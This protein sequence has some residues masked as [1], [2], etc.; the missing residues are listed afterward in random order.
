MQ[1]TGMNRYSYG[2][3]YSDTVSKNDLITGFSN[4]LA[5]V[6]DAVQEGDIF[7]ETEADVAP[8]SEIEKN[9]E[10]KVGINDSGVPKIEWYNTGNGTLPRRRKRMYSS[11]NDDVFPQVESELPQLYH[12]DMLGVKIGEGHG[13]NRIILNKSVAYIGDGNDNYTNADFA[14]L[15]FYSVFLNTSVNFLAT[16]TAL[17]EN[18]TPSWQASKF[19]GNAFNFYTYENVERSV[20]F[21]FKIFSTNDDEHKAAWERINF[22]SRLTMP[23]GYGEK[24]NYVQ[25]PIIQLTMGDIYHKRPAFIETLS[26][27]VDDTYTWD[28]DTPFYTLPKII[29]VDITLKL[30][31]SKEGTQ[32]KRLYDYGGRFPEIPSGNEKKKEIGA[33][34]IP[35]KNL[36]INPPKV[37]IPEPKIKIPGTPPLPPPVKTENPVKTT[38]KKPIPPKIEKKKP[39]PVVPKKTDKYIQKVPQFTPA[40]IDKTF[41][42][43]PVAAKPLVNQ[44]SKNKLDLRAKK[45]ETPFWKVKSFQGFGGGTFGG[46][47]AG[48]SF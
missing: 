48:G 41:V 45:P 29:N 33:D 40:K 39:E 25:P 18:W 22:L 38:D 9:T 15:R 6:L 3:A 21:Q 34:G 8:Y 23:Q 24:V 32:G 37:T 4:D 5:N 20:S 43:K 2:L 12:D 36:P 46:G 16:I 47:G 44:Q 28:T 42:A 7:L 27:S 14:T 11:K 1:K 35:L 30:L 26:Y 13:G 10:K 31:L 19:I 17:T